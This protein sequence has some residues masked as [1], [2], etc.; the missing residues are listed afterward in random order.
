MV[1]D[2]NDICKRILSLSIDELKDLAS[3][4]SKETRRVRI[5]L[6]IPDENGQFTTNIDHLIE[7]LP[8]PK[9]SEATAMRVFLQAKHGIADADMGENIEKVALTELSKR[10]SKLP[11]WTRE[12]FKFLVQYRDEWSSDEFFTISDPKIRRIYRGDDIDGDLMLLSE[13]GLLNFNEA[14]HEREIDFWS[15][16]FPG[17]KNFQFHYS[18]IDYVTE[19]G[20]DLRKPLVVLDFSDF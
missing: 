10:L 13:A 6:E 2:F 17:S 3:Y 1:W 20:I 4:V 7:A 14:G 5:E 18:F 19:C 9:L 8:K 12:V 11:R 15:I 16:H